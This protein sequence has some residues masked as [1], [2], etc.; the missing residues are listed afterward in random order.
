M[1][2]LTETAIMKKS[3]EAMRLEEARVQH[4][5]WRKWGPYL[6][7]RQWAQCEKITAKTAMPGTISL[8]IRRGRGH[9]RRQAE[10]LLCPE[11]V[12]R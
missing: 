4:V 11:P 9:F 8:T 2:E 6:S 5:P 3:A 10:S 1:D 7:E 12:E